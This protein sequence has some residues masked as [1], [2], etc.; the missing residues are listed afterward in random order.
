MSKKEP[1]IVSLSARIDDT[2][3]RLL[4]RRRSIGAHGTQLRHRIHDQMSS[5]AVLASAA[6]VGFLIGESTR[7]TGSEKS[8][9][10]IAVGSMPWM[11]SLL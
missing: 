5:P 1:S 11:Y 9:L 3:K 2:E 10:Q 4:E 8:W 7:D 6:G